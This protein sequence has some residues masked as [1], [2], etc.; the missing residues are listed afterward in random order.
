[1]TASHSQG[2]TVNYGFMPGSHGSN[3]EAGPDVD[4][5]G[6]AILD[7]RSGYQPGTSG[8]AKVS[9]FLNLPYM[10]T[11]DCVPPTQSNTAFINAVAVGGAGVVA[12][13]TTSANGQ[14]VN[15]PLVPFGQSVST[16]N[17]VR[18]STMGPAHT[19]GNTTNGTAS[20]AS[21][22]DTRAIALGDYICIAEGASSGNAFVTQVTAKTATTLTLASAPTNTVSGAGIFLMDR[23]GISIRI[24]VTAGHIMLADPHS[25]LSRGLRLVSSNAGDTTQNVII[26]GYD[27]YGVAMTQRVNLNGTTAVFTTK[28]FKHIVSFTASAALAGNLSAGTSD[29]YGFGFRVDNWEYTQALWAGVWV[30]SSTGTTVADT[31]SPATNLTGDVRGTIQVGSVG[32]GTPITGGS[33][34]DGSKR[35]LLS[36]SLPIRNLIAATPNDYTALFG[37]A[38]V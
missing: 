10:Y 11:S 6:S 21:V 34:S 7:V 2:P 23:N 16:G 3:P 20:I 14:Y 33:T 19:T 9:A 1:M 32:G 17:I 27:V 30:T 15:L 26:A 25:G 4:Y 35:V 13:A 8:L 31:T 38:Q 5:Q 18:V 28:T 37:V 24:G 12:K 29:V 22:G 36:Q